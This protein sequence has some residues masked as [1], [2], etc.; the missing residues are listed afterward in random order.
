MPLYYFDIETYGPFSKPHTK[1]DKI[2][3]IQYQKLAWD[4]FEPV[5]DLVIL[6]EWQ[7]SEKAILE[8]FY[9]RFFYR[10]DVWEFVPVGF[11][12]KYEW[13]MLRE[14]F[15]QYGFRLDG[16]HWRPDID[17]KH[18]VVLL[19]GGR[20]KGSSL[21]RFSKKSYNGSYVREWYR[22]GNYRKI[23]EYIEEE[24]EAFLELLRK[25]TFHLRKI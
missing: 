19:N 2:I 6:K 9:R 1:K 18:V 8:W 14:K 7:S 5:G 13:N 17:V 21:D 15:R 3:T 23:E 24:A 11:N 22:N 16:Y 12:L 4:T 20:F 10:R 25:V